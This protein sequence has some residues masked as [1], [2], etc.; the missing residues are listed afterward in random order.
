MWRAFSLL[1]VVCLVCLLAAESEAQ[2]LLKVNEAE[3][4]AVF[5][6]NQLQTKLALDNQT[7][8][9]AG[10]VRLEILD[11]DD[12][13]LAASE[14]AHTIKRG[15]QIVP[16]TLGFTQAQ[17][18]DNLLWYRLRYAVMQ[19][20]SSLSV[21]G[22][23]SLSEIMPEL[24]ELQISAPRNVYAGMRLRAHV[25]ALHPLTKK[26]IKNVN[27]TGE[28]S[29]DLNTDA[30]E[31]ELKIVAKGK[32]SD[33]GFMTL[34]FEIPPGANLDTD[35]EITVK[36][37]K[38]GVTRE[39]DADLD[40]SSESRVYLNLDKPI[41]Q[42][43]QKLFA[44]GLYLNPARRPVAEKEIEFEILDEEGETVYEAAVKTSRFGVAAL[45]WQIP[46][47]IKLGKY[48]IRVENGDDDEIGRSE[49]KIT[50]YDLPNFSINARADRTFYLPGQN[51]AEIVVSADYLFGKPVAAGKVRLVE[52]TERTWNYK[53]QRW[54]SREAKSQEGATDAE[55]KFV[56]RVDLTGAHQYL[57]KASW[58]RFE[59]LHFVA[60]LT[61]ATTNRTEQKR[62][63]LRISK[64]AIHIYF[65]RPGADV[66]PKLPYQFYISTFYADGTPARCDIEVKG[67]YRQVTGE[68]SLA[69]TKTNSY[70]ASRLEIR[71]PEKPFPA[72]ENQIDLQI[73]ARDQQGGTGT[74][75]DNFY[76]DEKEEQ[77]LVKTDK[78]IYLP[79]ENIEA[80][81]FSSEDDEI[82]LVDVLKN[83]SVIYSKRV[84]LGDGRAAVQIPFRPDFKGE[85]TI[86]VYFK[87]G[88]EDE[89]LI[90]HS[91]TVI[92]P[93][94]N[95]LKL[96]VK[97]L[98]TVYRPNEEAK[99]TFNARRG[100]GG[101][102][103]TA[104]GVVIL[105]KA[106]EE[107]A[108]TEQMPDNY[109]D[110]RRLAGTADAFGNLTRRDLNNLDLNK[111]PDADLQLA[112]EF[113]LVNQSY[114]PHF[115]ES[116]SYRQNF[117]ELFK[118]YFENKL[119]PF[120]NALRAH[121][122][123]TG[124]YPK[125]EIDLRQILSANG[126][127]YDELRDAWGTAYAAEFNV[128]RNL[129]IVTLKTAS[130]D[131]KFG[132]GDDFK[133]RE[134]RFEW[135]AKT[136]NKLNVFLNN[137]TQQNKKAPQTID[138]LKAVWRDAGFD[139]D[140][141]RD[142]WNRPLYLISFKYERNAQ[143]YFLENIGNLDG[144]TQ[145]VS[146]VKSVLQEIVL[147]K[148]RSAG[149]DAVPDNAD[150]FDLAA[151]S[152]V[153]SEKDLFSEPATGKISKIKTA[154]SS[155]AIAGTIYDPNGAV[156][157][158]MKV[159]AVNQSS[160]QAFEGAADENGEFLIVNL[161]SGKY[162]V[163]AAGE[164]GF[165][166]TTIENVVVSSMTLIK[167]EIWMSVTGASAEVTVADMSASIDSTQNSS[168][169][170]VTTSEAKSISGILS[171]GGNAPISTPR[172]REYF[173]ETLVWQP[174]LITDK[175]GRAE[176]K[177]TLADNLT[178][179]KLY[180]FGSTETGEVA[181]VEKEM[182]TFQPFFAELEPPKILTEGDEIAL[183]VPVR[184]YTD[185][186][187]KV[188]V[189]MTENDWSSLLN[190][191]TQQIEIAP[192]NTQNAIFSFRATSPVKEGK[193]KVTALAKTDS[194][195]I[196]KPVT[197]KPNGK[198]IVRTQS[199]LFRENAAFEVNFPINAFPNTRRAELK[200]YP[201]MLAHVAESVEGLLKR[202][203]GCGE[204]TTSSTYPNLMILKIEKDL[205]KAVGEQTKTQAQIYLQ[206]GYERLLNYQTP[207]GGFSYWG[208]TD[209]PNIALTA[210]VLRFLNDAAG[211][212]EVDET[213]IENAQNWLL[214]QQKT[215][216]GWRYYYGDID[217][218]TAY[219]ARSLSMNAGQN[220][221]TKKS[222]RAALELLKKRLPEIKNAHA[223]ANFA[224]AAIA[225]N[226]LETARR[227]AEKLNAMP[228][229]Y[230]EYF[231]WTSENTPF[232]GWGTTAQIE[233]TALVMQVLL[234][235]NENNKFATSLSRGVAYLLKSKDRYGVWYSTQTTVN[236]LDALILLQKSNAGE[237]QNAN[238]KAE[239]Y[240][241]GRKIQD[242][243]VDT[244]SFSNPLT[245][246]VLPYL[247]EPV[248][249]L[250][251]KNG[252]ALNFIQAQMVTAHY[253]PWKDVSAEDSPH[254]D[255]KVN[256]D[257]TE[258]KIGDEINCAVT[259]A[260][261]TNR[262]GMLLAEIGIPPGADVDRSSL[263]NAK[264]DGNISRYD[265]LPDKI[266][267][268]LWA[269]NSAANFNF[270]FKPRYGINAQTAPSTVY[271]YYNEEAKT[272]LAPVRFVVK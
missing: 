202:P 170:V 189:S 142:G 126:I 71:I 67:N 92:Y 152:V 208:K 42:P 188:S 147:F 9:F 41:Y 113:L 107:R 12:R 48:R 164:Y 154:N 161:P 38:N 140:V 256:F 3:T 43:S 155:G 131:K 243:S 81:I 7:S 60:Y 200:I 127:N 8:N 121:Y 183:P 24:F 85:L 89:R 77:I 124:E 105:D 139:V 91:K 72:A 246:D 6:A 120:E 233:T 29:L 30:D 153:S 207:S 23:V 253:L 55:G 58:K 34:D 11:A 171:A 150:D 145:Q 135:F 137:Y 74:L 177:F 236:V 78:T 196:E 184:N 130:A 5:Q 83:S 102:A 247:S 129:V 94:P 227:I 179:W 166:T 224:L 144:E 272:T 213:V 112:A 210:Y 194:D 220:E 50:R 98:K 56:A 35:G 44:R 248:N 88:D 226:D 20:N 10:K 258:T 197:V 57:Q 143:K 225:V 4:Q 2:T 257:K 204:Q 39:A 259:I 262:Y 73:F 263:E 114:Q 212:I 75:T 22:I 169:S 165:R 163:T 134:V 186:R 174:E 209:A 156:I 190:G 123:K 21:S 70:G 162:S 80:K 28:I 90:A 99:I 45:N 151:F 133:A 118:S 31:D 254:F 250:E 110:L 205:G 218:S 68:K 175:T 27:V 211:F 117:R 195:A 18:T 234:R 255:L 223:L 61:D 261:K 187:R 201:N 270:K 125:N 16:V 221:E 173:P 182:Q 26:P 180:V 219:L 32:T 191:A 198:E 141:L 230:K 193:Q 37:E 59:D 97:S 229:S 69:A 235:L 271:D 36:G 264:K 66:S 25:L 167:L 181:L 87:G 103:E 269:D 237:K 63:D 158:R 159:T 185:K 106:I 108:Q 100:A 46:A 54:E 244:N 222:L 52:E 86:A 267:V 84:R 251:I 249:R 104:L 214:K 266:I 232:Y 148:L 172:V 216:G 14:T 242:F 240:I 93:S 96:N 136:Q 79:N 109:A 241:N 122:E 95:D 215:D 178:T 115:F 265:V 228:Q 19:E 65:I 231:Y 157:P 260:R 1:V 252:D 245:I 64:E 149:A 13:V 146:R 15:R 62:F 176:L 268:Y 101:A 49:F 138:E 132:T 203:Y 47:D 160:K 168:T 82:V 217:S 119:Q 206:Q 239:I 116:D 51:T 199:E 192:N 111:T 238:E 33:E 128:E 53:E 17:A 76:L 40:V